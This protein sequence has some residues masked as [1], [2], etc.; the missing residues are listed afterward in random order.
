VT[1]GAGFIGSHIVDE[2]VRRGAQ[3]RVLDN[4]STGKRSNL[5]PSPLPPFPLQPSN[6]P[7]PSTFELIEGD[8]RNLDTV[9]QAMNGVAYVLHQAAIPSMPRSVA[10]PLTT[11]DVNVNSTLNMLLAAREAGVKRVVY[12]SSCAVYGDSPTLPK[13]EDMPTNPLSPYAASKLAGEAY[14]RAFYVT[15]GLPT[16][17]LRYFNVFGPRQDPTSQYSAVIPKFVT[18]L[19]RGEPPT[20]YGDGTQSRDFIYVSNV[21][22][23]NLLAC[24]KDE[25]IGQVMN[26]ACGERYTLLDLHRELAELTGT[27]GSPVFAPA[28]PGD[29]KHSLAAIRQATQVLGYTPEVDWRDGL[30]KTVEW[31]EKVEQV[32]RDLQ[33]QPNTRPIR[34]DEA[35]YHV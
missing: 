35:A 3:V 8:I 11:N 9:R 2:L 12:A 28:Q 4:L 34:E 5:Q 22:Q 19:L 21:V 30:R 1:G 18:A 31:Y 13:H 20:I 29:V 14:C 17:A 16:V 25:A 23:A 7:E 6:L 27:D 32:E 24:E 10:D 15:Y 26:V 33:S